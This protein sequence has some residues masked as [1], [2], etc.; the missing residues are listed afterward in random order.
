MSSLRAAANRAAFDK[1][2]QQK[3][4]ERLAPIRAMADR[5]A[6]LEREIAE[7]ERLIAVQELFKKP[8]AQLSSCTQYDHS[9]NLTVEQVMTA[10]GE[11]VNALKLFLEEKQG[12][13]IE[14]SGLLKVGKIVEVNGDID[15]T[16]VE[17][18]K[19]IWS[20]METLGAL[21][22]SDF[23]VTRQ[24]VAPAAP[25]IEPTV[26]PDSLVTVSIGGR[27]Q[28]LK[29]R[30][31]AERQKVDKDFWNAATTVVLRMDRVS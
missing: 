28:Q 25:A 11:A 8:S 10:T 21:S 7:Q 30:E 29:A 14:K 6:Q 18:L 23:T 24:P 20:L 22:Q 13:R 12:T 3:E 2:E 19:K 9:R 15:V 27:Q 17:N 26:D 5:N 16:N 31:V 4:F 1:E